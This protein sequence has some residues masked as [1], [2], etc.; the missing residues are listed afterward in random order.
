MKRILCLVLLFSFNSMAQNQVQFRLEH[1]PEI[2]ERMLIPVWNEIPYTYD[3]KNKSNQKSDKTI[4][5]DIL[6]AKVTLGSKGDPLVQ[7]EPVAKDVIDFRWQLDH[8]KVDG[9]VRVN[10]QYKKFGIKISHTEHFKLRGERIANAR[11]RVKLRYDQGKLKLDID[12]N[13]GFSFQKIVVTPRDGV[14]KTL[15]FIFDNVFSK[16]DVDNFIGKQINTELRKWANSNE[17]LT[18]IESVVNKEMEEFQK[19]KISIGELSTNMIVGI[20]DFS[21]DEAAISLKSEVTFDNQDQ[22]VHVCAEDL[23]QDFARKQARARRESGEVTVTHPLIEQGLLNFSSFEQ[24]DEQ[25]KLI[26]PLFCVG[27]K[28]FDK[29]GAPLG[30]KAN[31]D[32]GIGM[33]NFTYWVKPNSAPEF[34]YQTDNNEILVGMK[35][36]VDLSSLYIPRV[37]VQNAPLVAGVLVGFSPKFVSGKGLVLEYTGIEITEISGGNLQVQWF[38]LLPYANIDVSKY[39]AKLEGLLDKEIRAGLDND[40]LVVIDQFVQLTN[41]LKLEL[42]HHELTDDFHRVE[43]DL[44]AE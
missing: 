17:L 44:L 10:F 11:S 6:N 42:R 34:I 35:F 7:L 40:Q 22:K 31:I 39:E 37:R 2:I 8:L 43:F 26:E 12:Y 29:N 24:F 5:A 16:A 28:E 27:Y 20:S 23:M 15:R 18:E 33:L 21:I 4:T 30:E 25:G 36:A 9:L 41:Q 32:I 19:N 3:F 14:G 38:P 13:N 1:S